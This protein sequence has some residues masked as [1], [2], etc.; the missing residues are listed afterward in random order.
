M[1]INTI[2][3]TDKIVSEIK[4][5][6]GK[7][8]T[9]VIGDWGGKGNISYISTPNVGFQRRLKRDF[10][11]LHIDEY[12]T[13]KIHH[14]TKEKTENLKLNINGKIKKIH[15]VLTFKKS[16]GGMCCINRDKNAVKN[17]KIITESLLT[18]QKRPQ[19]YSRSQN[20]NTGK[21]GVN[22]GSGILSKHQ[23]KKI[24]IIKNK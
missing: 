18:H 20:L 13:S 16:D 23:C 3:H 7:D 5:F 10:K 14:E 11:V 2:R 22:S 8:A 21:T 4:T 9:L 1:Y 12:N 19:E 17:M 15:T 24:K 6:V